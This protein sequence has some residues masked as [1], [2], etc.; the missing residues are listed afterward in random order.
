[1][2]RTNT[3]NAAAITL[4]LLLQCMSACSVTGSGDES[5]DET[6]RIKS[7]AFVGF[8]RA[9]LVTAGEGD[10]KI[11]SNAGRDWTTIPG[12]SVGGRFESVFFID[13]Q[14]GVAVNRD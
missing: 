12:A 10:L 2:K 7:V 13:G 4:V 9:W 3:S 11:T 8:E 5:L 1:M 14:R 6:S